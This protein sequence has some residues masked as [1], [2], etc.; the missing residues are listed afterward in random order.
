MV[1]GHGHILGVPPHIDDP[2]GGE[3]GGGQQAQ[4]QVALDQPPL[5]LGCLEGAG[6]VNMLSS[7]TTQFHNPAC[8]TGP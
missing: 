4:R 2:A 8:D 6:E 1:V 5:A 3:E 7:N